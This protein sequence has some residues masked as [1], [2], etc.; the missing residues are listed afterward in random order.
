MSP[1]W[2]LLLLALAPLASA[3]MRRHNACR[4]VVDDF[5]SYI[6][7]CEEGRGCRRIDWYEESAWEDENN[8]N[9]N[10]NDG[11]YR[12]PT[13][14]ETD[15]CQ[16]QLSPADQLPT[17]AEERTNMFHLE[18][19]RLLEEERN[20]REHIDRR[21]CELSAPM[22][23][24]GRELARDAMR[25]GRNSTAYPLPIAESAIGA[26]RDSLP[27]DYHVH[28]EEWADILVLMQ[29][30][31]VTPVYMLNYFPND[32][33][34]PEPDWHSYDYGQMVHDIKEEIPS[35][36]R[37]VVDEP[38]LAFTLYWDSTEEEFLRRRMDTWTRRFD[39]HMQCAHYGR[40]EKLTLIP[41]T[42]TWLGETVPARVEDGN[43]PW[44][45]H[46]RAL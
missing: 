26:L 9:D 36:Y 13:Y 20:L 44:P 14:S 45:P 46:P 23:E 38:V 2:F 22:I 12:P 5:D 41:E 29:Q 8:D 40:C 6:E 28:V 43:P 30:H 24:K 39:R 1:L 35:H 37:D 10:D 42:F 7:C 15:G 4:Y 21:A 11:P 18:Q 31:G 27:E 16:V 19:A 33:I 25:H 3:H 34:Q 32:G 17:S